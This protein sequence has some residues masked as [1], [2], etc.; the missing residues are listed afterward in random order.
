MAETDAVLAS[1]AEHPN[2]CPFIAKNMIQSFSTSN[3]APR[4]VNNV[5]TACQTGAHDGRTY[6]G[7]YGDVGAMVDAILTDREALSTV[8]LSDP[9]QGKLHHP[10]DKALHFM[11]ALEF[12]S[13]FGT[14]VEMGNAQNK[15]GQQVH[16][17][18][19]VFSYSPPFFAPNGVISESGLYAPEAN[20]LGGSKLL[21]YVNGLRAMPR[22]GLSSSPGNVGLG[23]EGRSHGY[24][25]FAPRS[26]AAA[27]AVSSILDGRAVGTVNTWIAETESRRD[28]PQWA[29]HNPSPRVD[30]SY[31]G[32][33]AQA[34]LKFDLSAYGAGCRVASATLTLRSREF[35]SGSEILGYRVAGSAAWDADATW[36][37]VGGGVDA[38]RRAAEPSFSFLP[39]FHNE[40]VEMDVTAD[41]RTWA[42]G[43]A[44]NQG[45][46]FVAT[47]ENGFTFYQESWDWWAT[48][49]EITT[50][51]GDDVVDELDVLLTGGRLSP[52]A[53][54]VIADAYDAGE[55]SET[56]LR[57]A[58]NLFT[59]TPE[60]QATCEG[61]P[62]EPAA[63]PPPPPP[64]NR[65]FKAAIMLFFH[66]GMDSY[67]RPS[68]NLARWSGRVFER[69]NAR[70]PDAAKKDERSRAR[71]R[72]KKTHARVPDAAK[73]RRTLACP[74]PPQNHRRRSSRRVP[75]SDDAGTRR[76]CRARAAGATPRRAS[77][78][79]SSTSTT[80]RRFRRCRSRSG[81]PIYPSRRRRSR[82]ARSLACTRR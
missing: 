7:K 37:S 78:W 6:S 66:G 54:D 80:E 46:V 20:F 17:A 81:R 2:I 12:T 67:P 51:A 52:E 5:V 3:P 36:D 28:V 23:R 82:P 33:E 40:Y 74:T 21:G 41:V 26:P 14:E 10:L 65:D 15:L 58:L 34:L 35:S 60:F 31:E 32:G 30:L 73:K 45:W 76:S 49:L 53:R 39:P 57:A 4:Y 29:H 50:T 8:V 56:R 19:S 61:E 55:T 79:T 62:G 42:D 48:R 43:E 9:N 71:R 24:L 64:S 38:T 68:G 25:G 75:S 47:S 77:R 22:Y 1:L 63:P 11:R 44:E 70:V 72:E 18:P 27:C 13:T 16:Y 59:L 69:T